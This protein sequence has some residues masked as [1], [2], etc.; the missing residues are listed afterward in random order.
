M[1]YMVGMY[2][3]LS[4]A[5]CWYLRNPVSIIPRYID[6]IF[7]TSN[8]S[9]STINQMLDDN[10]NFPPNIQLVRQPGK[11]IPF[12]D[13][14][15]ENKN[16]VLTISGYHKRAAESYVAPYNSDHPR[17]TFRTIIDNALLRTVRYSPTL[18]VFS[19]ERR[20][21]KLMLLISNRFNKFFNN[22]LSKSATSPLL[23]N[24]NDLSLY[25]DIY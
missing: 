19:E 25:I 17:H 9:L 16:D 6:D 14:F 11:S 2:R 12:L 15:I 7:F 10:N 1:K 13:V 21:T 24:E 3:L 20:S 23:N 5:D 22:Y 18:S 4:T 8:E